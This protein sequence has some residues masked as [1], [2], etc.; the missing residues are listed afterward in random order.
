MA[1]PTE[2]EK[3]RTW[4]VPEYVLNSYDGA[5][6]DGLI[7]VTAEEQIAS[8][9]KELEEARAKAEQLREALEKLYLAC[10]PWQYQ[11]QTS[12]EEPFKIEPLGDFFERLGSARAEARRSLSSPTDTECE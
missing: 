11:E 12:P 7:T 4:T 1:E 5:E 10:D 2:G 6:T 3:P 9:H 8:L